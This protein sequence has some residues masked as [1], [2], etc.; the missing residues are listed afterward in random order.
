MQLVCT[1]CGKPFDGDNVKFYSQGCRDLYVIAIDK[2][3]RE[4]SQ[5]NLGHPEKIKRF[6]ITLIIRL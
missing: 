3:T 5:N 1:H 6:I 2:R 4:A